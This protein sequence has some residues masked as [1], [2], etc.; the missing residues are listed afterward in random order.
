MINE[1]KGFYVK[2]GQLIATRV[3][4]FPEQYTSKLSQLQDP[5]SRSGPRSAGEGYKAPPIQPQ[6]SVL[7]LHTYI[8]QAPCKGKLRFGFGFCLLAHS[9]CPPPHPHGRFL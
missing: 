3:D 1:L 7:H 9:R 4:L 6:I 5:A 2:S 8:A